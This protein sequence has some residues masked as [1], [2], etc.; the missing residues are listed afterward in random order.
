MEPF[1]PDTNEK[2]TKFNYQLEQ[3]DY[4]ILT[5]NRTWGSITKVQDKYPLMSQFYQN[6]FAGKLDFEKVAEITSYPTIPIL[7][8]PIKDDFAEEAFTVYDHPKILIFKKQ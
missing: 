5:S 1:A 7:N 8:I 2:W 4:L 6:L 3:L